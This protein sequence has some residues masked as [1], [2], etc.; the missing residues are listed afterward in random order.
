[1]NSGPQDLTSRISERPGGSPPK[2][3]RTSLLLLGLLTAFGPLS[4]DFYLPALPVMT[5]ELGTTDAVAQLTISACLIGLAL[6]QVV[7][8][9]LSDRHGRKVPLAIGLSAYVVLSIACAAAPGIEALVAFRLVQGMAGGSSIVIARA[10]VRDTYGAEGSAR[11]FSLLVMAA[12]VA[13]IVSPVL[14]GQLLLFAS[15][16]GLFAA[17]AVL[18]SVLLIAVLL[19]AHES[20]PRESRHSGGFLRWLEQ[21]RFVT[22]DPVFISAAAVQCL[23]GAG[24]FTF[25][26]M[27][28]FVFQRHYGFDA[29]AYGYMFGVISLGIVTFSRINAWAVARCG[30]VALVG[31]G[32]AAAITGTLSLLAAVLFEAPSPVVV[33]CLFLSIASG[34][35]ISPNC[36]ALALSNQG[37]RSGTASGLLG[38]MQFG[39]GA[40]MGPLMSL[41]GATALSMASAMLT[42]TALMLVPYLFA[43]RRVR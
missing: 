26:G 2:A 33:G 13:P 41:A 31:W 27:S 28:A 36:H 17:L 12:G 8:G 4:L 16:R 18:V 19:R 10:M 37:L 11:A 40:A 34:G 39:L 43:L 24:M 7:A 22:R 35:L 20:L 42:T 9:P 14:G 32:I 5:A 3:Q 23:M 30:A 25:I 1:M 21:L 29:Q 6:G 38:L 15:W